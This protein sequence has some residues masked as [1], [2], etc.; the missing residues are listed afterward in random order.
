MGRDSVPDYPPT[1]IVIEVA[2]DAEP[3][4]IETGGLT[5]YLLETVLN[6]AALQHQTVWEVNTPDPEDDE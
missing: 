4:V 1:R 6:R 2:L 5:D 3:R